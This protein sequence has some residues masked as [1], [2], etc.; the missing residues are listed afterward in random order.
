MVPEHAILSEKEK[1]ELLTKYDIRPEQLPRI[2][3]T[4]PATQ[5]IG[6]KPGQVIKILRKSPTAK[7]TV[8]YRLVVESES[9]GE[10]SSFAEPSEEFTAS[11]EE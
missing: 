4:D 9:I 8:A 3:S 2:L 1:K 10:V 7:L 11:S 5:S 6:A